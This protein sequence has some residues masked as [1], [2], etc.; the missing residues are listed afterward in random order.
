MQH[1]KRFW[2]STSLLEISSSHR[3]SR[4]LTSFQ[5]DK[6]EYFPNLDQPNEVRREIKL[7]INPESTWKLCWDMT[8]FFIILYQAL[9]IPFTISFAVDFSFTSSAELCF[10]IYF[11]FDIVLTLNT[12][13]YSNGDLV[14]S[15]KDIIKNYMKFWFW[16]DFVSTFP[17]DLIYD[18][19]QIKANSVR[20]APQLLRVLKFYKILRL[21][22]L[23]KL[24]KLFMQIEEYI[25]SELLTNFLTVLRLV[26]YAFFIT[27]W[28]ACIWYYISSLESERYSQTWL[29]QAYFETGST[30]ELYITSLYWAFTTMATVGYGDIVP[31]TQNEIIFSIFALLV[32]CAMFAY[33][34]GSIG[35]LI[36]EL[37]EDERNYREKC[38]SINSFMKHNKIPLDLRF[39]TRRY[40]EYTWEQFKSKNIAETEILELL[41][42][43]LREEVYV[44][45]RGSVMKCCVFLQKFQQHFTQQLSKLLEVHTFAPSDIIFEEGER[46]SSM[47][48]IRTGEIELFQNSTGTLLKVLK[49][50]KYCGEISMI[51]DTPR[52]CS[53]R[54]VDFLESL[55]LEKKYFDEL[56]EKNPESL[57]Y[58]EYIKTKCKDGDLSALEI[59]CYLCGNIGHVATKCQKFH[60]NINNEKLQKKWVKKRAINTRYINPHSFRAKYS[61]K[62]RRANLGKYGI[63]NVIGSE[64]TN[65]KEFNYSNDLIEKAENFWDARRCESDLSHITQSSFRKNM[66]SNSNLSEE[67]ISFQ[68]HN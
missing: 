14:E 1:Q 59:H 54:S 57:R 39:R 10:M 63:V 48:F 5:D 56:L 65:L 58:C 38:V 67:F 47:V 45:T 37:T 18:E 66:R 8:G 16:I 23:A 33:T 35:V 50:N 15:R 30:A 44:Y 26:I 32:S 20:S 29:S 53:A 41:S 64:R 19:V 36:S 40:L 24:K 61:M 17:Y 62:K 28:V 2:S 13:F 27:H 46:T 9:I 11:M 7:V 4:D 3:P 55:I 43:P 51:C 42:E 22:R 52:C 49:N 31:I 34:V 68:S 25:N 60:L 21:L 12:A 6:F